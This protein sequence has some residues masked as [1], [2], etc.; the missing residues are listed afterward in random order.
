MIALYIVGGLLLLI[1]I[2]LLLR[3]SVAAGYDEEGFSL[4]IGVGPVKIAVPGKKEKSRSEKSEAKKKKRKEQHKA[5]KPKKGG[6]AVKLKQLLPDILNSL[7]KLRRRLE[8]SYLDLEYTAAAD[9]AA[10]A[11]IR[12]GRAHAVIGAAMPA[13]ENVLNIKKRRFDIN[14]SFTETES[15]IRF[16]TKLSIRIYQLLAVAFSFIF[17]PSG[18]N[19]IFGKKERRENN[20]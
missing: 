10:Q 7:G 18:K 13:V 16:H 14:V 20:G 4:V 1:A 15:K 8:V 5:E 12:Y 9:D 11:A 3:A 6:S 2:I 19:L 17:S